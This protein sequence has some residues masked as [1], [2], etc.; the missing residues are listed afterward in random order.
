MEMGLVIYCIMG[1]YGDE[2]GDFMLYVCFFVK[3][4]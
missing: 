3:E 4:N 2:Y 1:I